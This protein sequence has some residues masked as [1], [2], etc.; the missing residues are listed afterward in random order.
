FDF[1]SEFGEPLGG[2]ITDNLALVKYASTRLDE[3]AGRLHAIYAPVD[4]PKQRRN[5]RAAPMARRL[6]WAS[7]LDVEKRPLLLCAIGRAIEAAAFKVTSEVFGS[8]ILDQFDTT[9]LRSTARRASRGAACDFY[10][11][12]RAG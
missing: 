6:L 11:L 7:R 12:R 4:P 2:V 9:I 8:A 3:L 5:Y 1:R 10:A